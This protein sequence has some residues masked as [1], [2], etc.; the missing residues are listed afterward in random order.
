M[1]RIASPSAFL[2]AIELSSARSRDSLDTSF[3]STAVRSGHTGGPFFFCRC[4]ASG[5][6]EGSEEPEVQGLRHQ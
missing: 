3:S 2:P 4:A 1:F 6:L 5:G